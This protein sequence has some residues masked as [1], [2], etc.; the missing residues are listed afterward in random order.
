MAKNNE[1]NVFNSREEKQMTLLRNGAF[2]RVT[3][4]LVPLVRSVRKRYTRLQN[5]EEINTTLII[6]ASIH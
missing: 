4:E 1:R 6:I 3:V 2:L 5:L